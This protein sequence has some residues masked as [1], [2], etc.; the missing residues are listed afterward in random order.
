MHMD[1]CTCFSCSIIFALDVP[2]TGG[3][4]AVPS[5]GAAQHG[6]HHGHGEAGAAQGSVGHGGCGE[7]WL[8][9]TALENT[10]T[11]AVSFS[12][13]SVVFFL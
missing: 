3:V 6:A 2:G 9:N 13:E 12:W 8:G 1:I 4:G 7:R 5:F 11:W 10:A